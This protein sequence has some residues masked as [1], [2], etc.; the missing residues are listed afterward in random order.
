MTES[1]Q[2]IL[3]LIEVRRSFR[4]HLLRL[5]EQRTVTITDEKLWQALLNVDKTE[6]KRLSIRLDVHLK[7]GVIS[8]VVRCGNIIGSARLHS[9]FGAISI[10]IEP[11]VP[12]SNLVGILE[13]VRS[14]NHFSED[15]AEAYTC[16]LYTSPSPRD[17]RGSRM[18]SS[19]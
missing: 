6:Y 18:P 1:V 9:T 19:A 3:D 12:A 2:S 11:K 7:N 17:Q 14:G 8:N 4:H 16:L 5:E 13:Y 15:I 10:V